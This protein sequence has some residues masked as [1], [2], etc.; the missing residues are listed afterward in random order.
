MRKEKWVRAELK[1]VKPLLTK[2]AALGLNRQTQELAGKL[3]AGSDVVFEDVP[4]A[5]FEAGFARPPGADDKHAILYLHGG[6]YTAGGIAHAKGFGSVIAERTGT[7]TFCPAYRLAPEYPYP[8][9]L[10]DAL[11]AY[12]YVLKAGYERIFFCGESA[13]GGLSLAL[14]HRLHTLGLPQ[15]VGLVAVS[16]WTDLTLS[17]ESVLGNSAVDPSLS[18]E[19]LAFDADCY[20]GGQDL[21]LPEISPLF[22]DLSHIP[23]TLIFAGSDELLL[24]DSTRLHEALLAAGVHSELIA[25]EGMWH[26]YLMYDLAE[27]Q[28]DLPLAARFITERLYHG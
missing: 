7:A 9:A 5:G 26:V 21:R 23:D 18:Y 10:D 14:C 22:G 11:A 20:A 4:M 1:L 12:R 13:G 2:P 6:G 8:A 16:P 24:S 3:I 15:P 27:R 25:A 28:E 17:G 19:Q